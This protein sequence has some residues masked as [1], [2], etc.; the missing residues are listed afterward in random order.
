MDK[1]NHISDPVIH[2][3]FVTV[4]TVRGGLV[5]NHARNLCFQADT[6]EAIINGL[7]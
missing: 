1:N 7:W 6:W 2:H 5:L 4:D 3:S